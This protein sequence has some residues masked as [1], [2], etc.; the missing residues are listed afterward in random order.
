M[1]TW[2]FTYYFE[3]SD[4]FEWETEITKE[5]EAL[6]NQALL[7][8]KDLDDVSELDSLKEKVYEEIR[9]SFNEEI[10]EALGEEDY[11]DVELDFDPCEGLTV[12]FQPP[13]ED[14]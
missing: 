7:D 1:A 6:I 4:W 12:Y 2:T 5:H 11:E 9:Q 13:V 8:G 10:S 3:G 14:E